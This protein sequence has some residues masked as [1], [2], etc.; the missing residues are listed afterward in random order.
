MSFL[1]VFL[2]GGLGAVLRYSISVFIQKPFI[3]FPF[4]TFIANVVAC[5]ILVVTL[6]YLPGRSS[7]FIHK[8]LLAIGFC[9]GLST[10]STFSLETFYLLEKGAFGWASFNILSSVAVCLLA[11]YIIF[12]IQH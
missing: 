4:A 2:G 1:Y 8:H 5:V 9:G 11:L 12:A 3:N 6:T 7:E 10:F